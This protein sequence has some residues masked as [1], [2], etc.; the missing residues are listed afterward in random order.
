MDSDLSSALPCHLPWWLAVSPRS[1]L[2]VREVDNLR[3]PF[4]SFRAGLLGMVT[5]TV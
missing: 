1:P 5:T 3:H 4:L 2:W